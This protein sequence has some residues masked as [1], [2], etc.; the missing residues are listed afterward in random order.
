[1]SR[2][3]K[4]ISQENFEEAVVEEIE[5]AEPMPVTEE[6][7]FEAEAA[8]QEL[9]VVDAER[10]MEITEARTDIADIE[11]RIAS[12]EAF[13]EILQ[14][15]LETRQFSPQLAAAAHVSLEQYGKLFGEQLSTPSLEN[16]GHEDLEAY[17]SASLESFGAVLKGL[18]NAAVAA[19]TR[20]ERIFKLIG[21]DEGRAKALTKK[22]D[23]LLAK[24][25]DVNSTDAVEVSTAGV[26]NR[27]NFAGKFPENLPKALAADLKSRQVLIQVMPK[28]FIA[29]AEALIEAVA[30]AAGEKAEEAEKTLQAAIRNTP[31]PMDSL[32]GKINGGQSLLGG[33]FDYKKVAPGEDLKAMIK[34]IHDQEPAD[35]YTTKTEDGPKEIKLTGA[36][37]AAILKTVKQQVAL[38]E[39]VAREEKEVFN[40]IK[41]FEKKIEEAR[42]GYTHPDV[43]TVGDF[44]LASVF[45]APSIAYAAMVDMTRIGYAMLQLSERAVAEL[46]KAAK[47]SADK[48]EAAE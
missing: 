46:G 44:A 37:V 14:H 47:K 11:E 9:S 6:E 22:A 36:D 10:Q 25:K 17:Y 8:L 33:K 48:D 20:V 15:G 24:L 19:K 13:M 7:V 21:S 18:K 30:K 29:H 39:H 5:A 1:M 32:D 2:L 3:K 12:V 23:D 35:T 27:I 41:S 38:I 16:H 42:E 4:Y 28:K 26:I 43:R 34:A 45:Y 40:L 31:F